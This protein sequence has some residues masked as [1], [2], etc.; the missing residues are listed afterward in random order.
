MNDFKPNDGSVLRSDPYPE[1]PFY[2]PP[3]RVFLFIKM[4]VLCVVIMVV[5]SIVF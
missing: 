5:V 2:E 3:K 1:V 4:T